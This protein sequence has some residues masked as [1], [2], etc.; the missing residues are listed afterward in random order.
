[1]TPLKYA[2]LGHPNEGKSSVVSTLTESE[3]VRISPTPGQTTR[4]KSYVI[5]IESEEV[6]EIIDT[7]GFQNPAATLQWFESW[8][9]DESEMVDAFIKAHQQD[10]SFHHDLE[11]MIPLQERAGV[12]YVA[13]ASRP[14]RESDRQE[15]ELL[16]YIGLPRM[17]LLNC[18]RENRNFLPEWEAALKRRFNLVREFNAHRASFSE[19]LELFDAMAHLVPE[20]AA[21]LQDIRKRLQLEW[22]LRIEESVLGVES[23]LIQC[24]RHQVKI[25]FKEDKPSNPQLEK[26]GEKYRAD[27]RKFEEKARRQWRQLFHHESLPGST[28]GEQGLLS[29]ELFAEKVWELLGLSRSQL[30]IAGAITG[31]AAGAAVDIAAGGI[32]FGIFTAGGALLGGLGSWIGGP[33]L[34]AK[35]LP[36]PGKRTLARENI[37]VGPARDPQLM[38]IL[39][40]RSLLYLTRLMNWAHGQRNH[41][42]FLADITPDS[43]LVRS[44]S[45]RQRKE[46]AAWIKIHSHPGHPEAEKA[47]RKFR[48]Q[49]NTWLHSPTTPE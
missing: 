4:C 12:L 19:R 23:L 27:L 13:D 33:K 11:I 44:W 41:E 29:E 45:E 32:T 14:L 17:A 49:V 46:F 48:R 10:K 35:R 1:M 36:L 30:A 8:Q 22:D 31:S 42:H 15:M 3:K 28:E 16:R 6:L 39:L 9:G 26:C 47:S 38:F 37:V 25:P 20:Q 7:P 5:S 21:A 18:K 43:G 24:L 2:V 40:D 34:G